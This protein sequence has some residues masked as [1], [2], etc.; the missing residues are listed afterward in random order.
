MRKEN[1]IVKGIMTV[2]PEEKRK[3]GRPRM[4]WIDG[5]E[6]NV[7]NLDMGNWKTRA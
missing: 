4:R 1:E 3:G 6:K 2:K 5:V 7:G